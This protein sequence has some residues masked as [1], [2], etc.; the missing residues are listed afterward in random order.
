MKRQIT[1]SGYPGAGKSTTGRMLAERLHYDFFSAG[2]FRREAAT[3]LGVDIDT[4]NILE[5]VRM[6]LKSGPAPGELSR[7][8][9]GSKY[10][11]AFLKLMAYGDTDILVDNR[12]KSMAA[13]R[14][15]IVV[16]GRLAYMHFPDAFKIFFY[17]KPG[18]AASRVFRDQRETE[19]A[20]ASE[21]EVLARMT[22]SMESDR[23]R[24]IGKYGNVGDCYTYEPSRYNLY[25]DT[26]NLSFNQVIARIIE[27]YVDCWE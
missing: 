14:D 12:Q 23:Q 15:C 20:F 24:Y 5:S 3:E 1:I 8:G 25:I 4:L 27:E 7:L 2:H 6:S 17:C 9:L 18:V 16:E 26:T 11:G 10:H 19:K 22:A 13:M 21:S